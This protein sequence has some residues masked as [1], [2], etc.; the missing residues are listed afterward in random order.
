M[1]LLTAAVS[2]PSLL[3][4]AGEGIEA[5]L[6]V[7]A[8]AFFD[9]VE[10]LCD[11]LEGAGMGGLFRHATSTDVLSDMLHIPLAYQTPCKISTPQHLSVLSPVGRFLPRLILAACNQGAD[12]HCQSLFVQTEAC[13]LRNY[14]SV[15]F[16]AEYALRALSF[17]AQM[18]SGMWRR[19]G[20]SVANLLYNY[21]RPPL[22]RHFRDLDICALQIATVWLGPEVILQNM[23]HHFE[24]V[25]SEVMGQGIESTSS[26][27]S[28]GTKGLLLSEL[29]KLVILVTTYL[30]VNLSGSSDSSR[31]NDDSK[32]DSVPLPA[33]SAFTEGM[34]LALD[35]LVA[36][37]VMGGNNTA[38]QLSAVK[39]LLGNGSV[40]GE[41]EIDE[42]MRRLCTPR[43]GGDSNGT[44]EAMFNFK[45]EVVVPL[46]DP[47]CPVLS[48]NE[49]QR[50]VENLKESLEKPAV[51]AAL[52]QVDGSCGKGVLPVLFP[53]A[54]PIPHGEMT[55]V[56]R[57]LYAP[58]LL[59]LVTGA[60]HMCLEGRRVPGAVD[61]SFSMMPKATALSIAT[62]CVHL[63]TLQ[64]HCLESCRLLMPV[65]SGG[66][67]HHDQ[68]GDRS[69]LWHG[70]ETFLSPE[71][72]DS[73]ALLRALI[74]LFQS[75]LLVNE[76]SYGRGL[77]W[78]LTKCGRLSSYAKSL[79][80]SLSSF[81]Y[82][83]DTMRSD[84]GGLGGT[85]SSDAPSNLSGGVGGGEETAEA[86]RKQLLEKRKAAARKRAM[87]AMQ[88]KAA[89]FGTL[90]DELE[91]DEKAERGGGD[92]S[93]KGEGLDDGPDCI[94]CR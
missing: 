80:C 60:L 48:T 35:R 84:V 10:A 37:K 72:G 69:S 73:E 46:F 28:P 19:N 25:P 18:D 71:C 90:L 38:S 82:P 77:E 20:M 4:S 33:G 67:C 94:I 32:E 13:M 6:N 52:H 62:R 27:L 68:I 31:S 74:D 51:L 14:K 50:A 93:A 24:C 65:V 30:P 86:Q 8:T 75:G 11:K 7:A 53:S 34:T 81:T 29:L 49:L 5:L 87:E 83:E 70:A 91:E 39:P 89:D 47:E 2:S 40:V 58:S 66:L 1:A 55:I 44:E 36:N 88:K 22:C 57:M 56:R 26:F 16:M 12:F 64:L 85:A 78:V 45:P 76:V 54:L 17:S 23:M 41:C 63:V 9:H 42:S 43:A 15:C 92:Q 61:K 79:V 21:S 3:S 59:R